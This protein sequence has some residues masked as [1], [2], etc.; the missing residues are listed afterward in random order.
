MYLYKITILLL[1]SSNIWAQ[2][3]VNIP[4]SDPAGAKSLD[5]DVMSARITIV[6]T[7]RS[8]ILVSY[9]TESF[10]EDHNDD[11]GER[12]GLKKISSAGVDLEIEEYKNEVSIKSEGWANTLYL[13]LEVPKNINIDISKNMGEDIIVENIIGDVNMEAS[14]GSIYAKGI[15]GLVNASSSTGEISVHFDAIPEAKSMIF[16][17]ETSEIDLTM[18]EDYKAN[19]KMRTDFG[20][21]YS[22]LDIQIEQN[23]DKIKRSSN[24]GKLKIYTDNWTTASLNGGGP[25]IKIQTKM[26]DIF[27]RKKE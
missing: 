20:D 7:D 10:D 12:S 14:I 21:I 3:K 8:D 5:I 26:G 18:P 23:P 27:L 15:T 24:D 22:D 2:E 6:G 16:S 25:E 17:S 11:H 1:I 13:E 4:F 9:K 19:L